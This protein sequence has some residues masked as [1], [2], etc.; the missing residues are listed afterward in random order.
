MNKEEILTKLCYY[1]LR[2]PTGIR[3]E[4]VNIPELYDEDEKSEYGEY[5]KDDCY[6]DNCFSGRTELAELAL[7]LIK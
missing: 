7:S 2:N 3:E 5:A 6:C 1:D 4:F